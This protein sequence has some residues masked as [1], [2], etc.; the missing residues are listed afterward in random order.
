MKSL[1]LAFCLPFNQKIDW[2]MSTVAQQGS[3]PGF[4]NRSHVHPFGRLSHFKHLPMSLP[5]NQASFDDDNVHWSDEN[6][7]KVLDQ[8]EQPK[9]DY[10]HLSPQELFNQL[11]SCPAFMLPE[12]VSQISDRNVLMALFTQIDLFDSNIRNMAFKKLFPKTSGIPISLS[13]RAIALHLVGKNNYGD[14]NIKRDGIEVKSLDS[15]VGKRL[16]S[17]LNQINLRAFSKNHFGRENFF[18]SKLYFCLKNY[19]E[20][21]YPGKRIEIV[22]E[23]IWRSPNERGLGLHIDTGNAIE[24][25]GEIIDCGSPSF[26]D[27]TTPFPTSGRCFRRLKNAVNNQDQSRIKLR[28]LWVLTHAHEDNHYSM[29]FSKPLSQETL[30]KVKSNIPHPLFV[31]DKY[32]FDFLFPRDQLQQLIAIEND[33]GK[34]AIVFDTQSVLHAPID[35]EYNNLV[36][37]YQRLSQEP[38]SFEAVRQNRWRESIDIRFAVWEPFEFD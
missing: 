3:H 38:P 36:L 22:T 14:L 20:S 26:L 17:I 19:L 1:A 15:R 13:N 11:Q 21:L 6:E 28:N 33:P 23:P 30:K 29:A 16:V 18:N 4:N 37:F 31:G 12:M 24:S 9:R 2:P 27:F 7:A 10:S 32:T 25:L 5:S 34:A 8:P 35:R